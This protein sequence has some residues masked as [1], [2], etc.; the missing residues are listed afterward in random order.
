MILF[1]NT[2]TDPPPPLLLTG[3]GLRPL[4]FSNPVLLQWRHP[5]AQIGPSDVIQVEKSAEWNV[6]KRQAEAV[7][8]EVEVEKT[9]PK[10]GPKQCHGFHIIYDEWVCFLHRYFLLDPR[11]KPIR[12]L[13]NSLHSWCFAS[14]DSSSDPFGSRNAPSAMRAR[15]LMRSISESLSFSV[16]PSQLITTLLY[17]KVA[18]SN[19]HVR[20]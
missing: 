20:A 6:C 8:V 3:R 16:G 15:S 13:K 11:S 4:W 7:S 1:V 2:P 5:P 12:S 14:C 10:N 18:L 19:F 17:P 9:Q